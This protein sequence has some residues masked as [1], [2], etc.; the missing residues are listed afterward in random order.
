MTLQ[1]R[2][3]SLLGALAAI[4]FVV[5]SCSS[6][7]LHELANEPPIAVIDADRVLYTGLEVLFSGEQSTDPNEDELSYAWDFGDGHIGSHMK[8]N[9]TYNVDGFFEVTLTVTDPGGLSHSTSIEVLV[10][11]NLPPEVQLEAPI[12]ALIGQPLLI[13]G[14]A[15]D[16][17]G[18]ALTYAWS[19]GE[20]GEATPA[21]DTP[22]VEKTYTVEGEYTIT[23][24]V[25]DELGASAS[26]QRP[27]RLV[28]N[29]FA[30]GQRWEGT[31]LCPQGV[32]NLTLL[33][34]G[35]DLL[36]VVA[37]FD[38]FHEESSSDGDYDMHGNFNPETDNIE[39][40]PDSWNTQPS[41]YTEVGMI[42]VVSEE[43][44]D[45]T[46]DG[47]ITHLACGFFS[48]KLVGT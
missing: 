47:D 43:P 44:D 3:P 4:A 23:L 46:F 5:S 7:S 21:A 41:G 38:F 40:F 33:I 11:E 26:A 39:F 12:A 45:T 16:P 2:C 13:R 9:H 31:Y 28:H 24:T 37:T 10:S 8:A 19:F 6:D 22:E 18:M 42:G 29:P 36:G 14:I 48:V 34:T 25:T 17:E 15:E 27:I 35:V 20:E 30:E 32:T 1:K